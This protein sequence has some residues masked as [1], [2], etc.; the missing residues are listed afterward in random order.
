[1]IRRPPRS[2]LFP[3]TTLFRSAIAS[4]KKATMELHLDS[5]GGPLIGT[6]S[7]DNTGGEY[8]FK[9]L[10]T[11][12]TNATGIHDLYM[13]FKGEDKVSLAKF[14]HWR[15]VDEKGADAIPDPTPKPTPVPTPKP[16]PVP[17]PSV[18]PTA[19]PNVTETPAPTI[20]PSQTPALTQ[21][22]ENKKI[23]SPQP[24]AT[25]RAV[26]KIKVAKVKGVKVTVTK[27]KKAKISWKKVKRAAG[28]RVMY[29]T[30]K[31]FKKAAVKITTKKANYVTKKLKKGKKYFIKVAAYRKDKAGKKVYGSFSAVK[32]IKVK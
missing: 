32:K 7:I 2:T 11:D 13:V 8:I 16:T 15:F 31:K 26:K 29:S 3:Y 20:V 14:D 30:D 17:T 12:I 22:S 28:Y 27:A 18:A 21:S 5:A 23:E 24:K 25:V 10:S 4:E 6:L 1:M 9:I 19:T